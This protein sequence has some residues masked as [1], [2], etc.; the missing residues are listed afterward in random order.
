MSP[1]ERVCYRRG[2][3]P[4]RRPAPRRLC[5]RSSDADA[6]ET[7]E[8]G[9]VLELVAAVR[10]RPARRGPRA[11]APARPT[12]RLDPPASWRGWARWPALFRRGDALLAEPV[13]DV[14]ARARPAPDR[15]QRARGPR[16]RRHRSACSAPHGW[17]TA[18]LRRVAE[19]APLAAALAHAAPGQGASS[20]ARA[21]ARRGRQRCSTPRAPRSPRPGARCR[22]RASGWCGSSRRCSAASTPAPRPRTPRVTVRGGR[23]VI[24]VRRDSRSRP[25]GIVHDE[26]GSAGTLFVEPSDAIE[27]GNA[28]REAQ[29]E[30]ERE[31]LRVLRELTEL[32]RPELRRARAARWRCASR[33]TT[34]WRAR[35]TPSPSRARCPRSCPRRRRSGIV[36]G[37]HPL[38]LAGV[39]AG[40]AVRPG[41]GPGDERTLLISGPEHRRQDGAA[42]GGRARRRAGAERHRAAGRRRQ[43]GCRSSAG[44]FADIGDR[45]S[46]A[47]S[48]ST[49]S[50]HVAHAPPD[51]RRRRRAARSCCSTR[52]AAAP[53]RPKA[54]RSPAATL[55]SLTARGALTLATTHLGALKDLAATRRAS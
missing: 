43:R 22:P 26:S 15:G 54:R 50:A 8:F 44:F 19:T 18:E 6:L 41:A 23:Y 37:R 24:P 34:W 25:A 30:E 12:T 42:Q 52:S 33:W 20:A 49:F 5:R 10:R 14:D 55:A 53:I 7:L 16:S 48:L 13:P 2:A 45:Q 21:V 32:L 36:N 39:G 29:V 31:V 46:I 38:L 27:L 35:A 47:A 40:G 28:L 9:Q 3:D 11:R 1:V 51:P 17:C 4:D